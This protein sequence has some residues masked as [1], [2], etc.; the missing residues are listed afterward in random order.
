MW[1]V[2]YAL[3]RPYTIAVAAIM[4][5]I[6]GMLSIKSM[7]VDIFP[8]IDIPVVAV[9]WS[10]AGLSAEDM[11]RRVVFISERSMSTTVNGI[12]RI[13][14]E[15]IP[16]VGLLRV[17][18]QPG[19]D[20]GGAIAQINSCM[21]TV[22]RI[23]PPGM[24]P[25]N[26]VQFNASNVPVVQ[27]TMTSDTLPEEKIFDYATNFI[28]IKL[29][30][31]P[32]LSTPAPYGGKLRQINI[33]LDP[34]ALAG[35]GLSP[36]DVVNALQASNIILPAGT[37]RIGLFEY[38]IAMNSSP[39]IVSDFEKI[40]IKVVG[41]RP[42]VIGDVAKIS[43]SF[44]D[45]TNVVRVDGRRASYL[46][47]LR[48]A[49]ASTLAVV[50]SVRKAIPDILAVAPQ[51]LKIKLDFDQS[52]FVRAAISSV[53]HEAVVSSLLVSL[54][55][56]LFLGSWR[57]VIIVCTS[58]PL[59][60][61]TS[62]IGLKLTGNSIN[63]MTL[64]GLSLAI[65]MLVD[66][67]IVAVE[68]IHRNRHLGH[69]LTVAIVNGSAQIALPAIMATL[70]ICIVFSPVALLTGPARFLFVPMALAVVFAMLASYVLSRTLVPTL[71]RMLMGTET[72]G[73]PEEQPSSGGARLSQRGGGRMALFERLQNAYG[74]VLSAA[75]ERRRFTL[76][77]FF[78]L[79]VAT[80]F[81]P[82]LVG[83][84]FFPSTDAG[85][86]KLHFRAPSGTRIE[87]TER[88]VAQAEERIRAIIP[89]AELQT[90]NSMIGL[91]LS[92]NLAFVPSDNVGGM[93]AEIL[94]ALK[95][96]HRPTE[97][98]MRRIRRD[99]S[100][101]F[102]GSSVYFQSA[103]IVSQVLNFGLAAPIDVQIES[104]DFMKSYAYARRLRDGMRR[105]PGA[106]DVV[107]KQ[108]FDY[109]NLFVDVDR[110]RASEVGLTQRDVAN[111]LL[112]TLSS[113]QLVAPSYFVNPS[114]NVNYFV[115]VKTPLPRLSAVQ[116]VLN[117]PITP[118][119]AGTLLQPG[120][121]A[122]P[123]Q[124]LGSA[125]E[126][127]GN[128]GI[129]SSLSG[130][131]EVNHVNVQRIVDVTANVEGRDLGSVLS[132][133]DRQISA[134]GKLPT[135]MAIHVRGQGEIMD[136]AFRKLGLGLGLAIAL[137]YLLMV[138]LFQSWLDPFIVMVAVPGALIGILWMLL[139][140]GTTIN[141][142]SFLG[143]IMAVGIAA[144][145]SILLVS[146]A[147]DV[148]VEKGLAPLEGA[149]QAGLTR[150][151][152]VLMTAVAMIIGMLPTALA[153]G[154]GGEQNAPLGRAVIGGLLVATAVTLIVVPVVYSL[155]RTGLPT[156]HLL[157]ER[158]R[159][160]E[161]GLDPYAKDPHAL[162]RAAAAETGEI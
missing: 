65:G 72:L 150:L 62:V 101:R 16:G 145:N 37:A 139:L 34:V 144:S 137:V 119:S 123:A 54:M 121:F 161:A 131:D 61:L 106:E 76:G 96:K 89:A 116:D 95:G 74:A 59:A 92:F 9:V 130:L 67:A 56:L 5:F 160:E 6:L 70:A 29:F 14:S 132:G 142:E 140:T 115:V 85:L 55:I 17:Y 136:E 26:I 28:R 22:L 98:Y 133:I 2:R 12:S 80:A 25:P 33:D 78:A 124:A 66:D 156:L 126:R 125:S 45:Q 102:P 1:I 31:I 11:E 110:V 44:A 122:P 153:L 118:P 155:L 97:G 3:R 13:E 60:I 71:S 46:N 75:L 39:S 8:V 138:V 40:P 113:S 79:I 42:V 117:T 4:I 100:E 50:A 146:F 64:G 21:N 23:V 105:V 69:P 162:A 128:L 157:D 112:T 154:E 159:R 152:P 90:V 151:R 73:R 68:N 24:T 120:G 27:L 148:R 91:P 149:Y 49:D 87:E 134:L 30:T 15:S 81:L 84:D 47:I 82:F 7:L 43:D 52:V 111:S 108:V 86:M 53:L 104:R 19:T 107:I 32:G 109:P 93:D 51:G 114:N 147:N 103:D 127:L 10:Y 99:L 41:G 20:I 88:L 129:L 83:T 77:V 141:V 36:A 94:I 135:G 143:S 57:S 63:I 18:F 48:K 58:I 38:N 35:K 158:F